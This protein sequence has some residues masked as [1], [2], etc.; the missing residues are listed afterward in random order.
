MK[1]LL[2]LPLLALS[3]L[4]QAQVSLPTL[5]NYI[6]DKIPSNPP[7]NQR[8]GAAELKMA[9]NAIVDQIFNLDSTQLARITTVT[10]LASLSTSRARTVH[11]LDAKR[12]G[13]FVYRKTGYTVD[14][15]VVYAAA[16]GG[17]YVR[18]DLSE[19]TPE[20]FGALNNGVADDTP[21]I[22]AC[23]NSPYK[24]ITF[25][26]AVGNGF[27]RITNSITIAGKAGLRIRA[28]GAKVLQADTTKNCWF[29][30][31]GSDL[32][33]TGGEYGYVH[34]I[35]KNGG[36]SQHWFVID[37]YQGA[38]LNAVYVSSS[39]EMC[40]AITQ[41]KNVAVRNSKFE[42]AWRDGTY[43][44]HSVNVTYENND[45]SD[46]KDDAASFHDYGI[47][48][49][50]AKRDFMTGTLGASQANGWKVINCRM[51]RVYQGV[52]SVGGSSE[53]IKNN[54]I[55]QTVNAGI[56]LMNQ[57]Y[58]LPGGSVQL[59]NVEVEGNLL[60]NTCKTTTINGQ[61]CPNEGWGTSG[62][63]ALFCASLSGPQSLIIPLG[64]PKRQNNIRFK[65]NTVINSGALIMHVSSVD[66]L[67]LSGNSG[68]DA[69]VAGNTLDGGPVEIW[70]C[71]K[72]S[73]ES[74]N[75]IT[76]TRTT[77]QHVYG[78]KYD[79]VS[80]TR[81]NWTVNGRTGSDIYVTNSPSL[82]DG[83]A[84]GVIKQTQK[85]GLS[86]VQTSSATNAFSFP[87]GAPFTPSSGFV[88]AAT[89]SADNSKIVSVFFD[90]TSV[91]IFYNQNLTAGQ[92]LSWNYCV[93]K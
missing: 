1:K 30:G 34:S 88:F 36:G 70:E 66:N 45:Y 51:N 37:R 13:L 33:I 62:R 22:N 60:T 31:L 46:I 82:L 90:A 48:T 72:L 71:T 38:T 87:H 8:A 47:D 3:L 52:S 85:C 43:A 24:E 14:N 49:P 93:F 21:A 42:H 17:F 32:E 58:G 50:G 84:M 81:R 75:T 29:F 79:G 9:F 83:S 27:Y 76:D 16:G 78:V 73:E 67:L 18:Q 6:N 53:Q 28:S 5:K 35:H 2:L 10:D 7:A 86:P 61:V 63:A 56:A 77:V 80:G 26:P 4:A 19:I 44:H 25:K 41:S 59:G 92:P 12:G 55:N 20:M 57:E 91:T 54:V 40:V 64:Q 23:L 74:T 69:N 68:Q 65:N 39:P 11:V 89:T 15:G